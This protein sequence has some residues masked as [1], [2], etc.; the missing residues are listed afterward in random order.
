VK[1]STSSESKAKPEATVTSQTA[2]VPAPVNGESTGKKKKKKKKNNKSSDDSKTSEVQTDA[3]ETAASPGKFVKAPET[4]KQT[5]K[6]PSAQQKSNKRKFNGDE[7]PHNAKK[8]KFNKNAKKNDSNDISENRLKAFGINPKK[9]K[10]KLK[11]GAGRS[12]QNGQQKNHK[13]AKPFNK[14][15]M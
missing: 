7:K 6:S 14:K 8:M 9:F 2:D 13:N 1:P 15:K 3:N 11:Y 5:S 10:N 4:P 12:N